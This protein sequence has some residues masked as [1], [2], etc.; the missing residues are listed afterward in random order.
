MIDVFHKANYDPDIMFESDL[1]INRDDFVKVAVIDSDD[2]GDAWNLT[3]HTDTD[4]TKRSNVDALV[5]GACRS[6]SVG[7]VFA[8][9]GALHL[10]LP[11]GYKIFS[12][13]EAITLKP[14]FLT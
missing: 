10:I 6:S 9:N 5:E 11:I 7:D 12:W 4:W 3:Q 13:G 14:S 8:V 2:V 1:Q